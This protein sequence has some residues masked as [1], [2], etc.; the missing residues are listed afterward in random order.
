MKSSILKLL[1]MLD[2]LRQIID[3]VMGQDLATILQIVYIFLL[4]CCICLIGRLLPNV[5]II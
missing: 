1:K 2:D 3:G 5:T 4:I